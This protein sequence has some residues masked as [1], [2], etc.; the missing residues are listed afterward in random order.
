MLFTLNVEIVLHNHSNLAQYLLID[1][2][3]Y[4]TG[5]SIHI[6]GGLLL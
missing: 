6:D 5:Q 3:K 1:K 2:S 4:I